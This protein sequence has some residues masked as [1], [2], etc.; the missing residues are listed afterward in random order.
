MICK[1]LF[2]RGPR[3]KNVRFE[4]YGKSYVWRGSCRIQNS[5]VKTGLRSCFASGKI[6]HSQPGFQ[7]EQCQF[8][9]VKSETELLNFVTPSEGTAESSRPTACFHTRPRHRRAKSIEF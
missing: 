3:P 8:H 7:I 1:C 9:A 5:A 2:C 6:P 4:I